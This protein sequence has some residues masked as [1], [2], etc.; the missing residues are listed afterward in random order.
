MKQDTFK[1]MDNLQQTHVTAP[2]ITRDGRRTDRSTFP[3]FQ[4]TE[5]SS[6]VE[7]FWIYQSKR[8]RVSN[9]RVL[10]LRS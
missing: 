8:Y 7:S 1:Q 3:Q 2:P 10:D 4:R 9:R 5:S 6:R